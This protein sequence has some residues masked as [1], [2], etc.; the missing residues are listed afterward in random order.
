M[1]VLVVV[2]ENLITVKDD[3]LD[4]LD[5]TIEFS[6]TDNIQLFPDLA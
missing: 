5:D 1:H 3:V 4:K 6:I 2:F